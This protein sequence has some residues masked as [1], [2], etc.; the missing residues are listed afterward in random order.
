MLV[1]A[2]IC[3]ARDNIGMTAEVVSRYDN[4]PRQPRGGAEVSA[5][6]VKDYLK[7]VYQ[8]TPLLNA[9]QEVELSK[10]IE[11]GLMAEHV[12]GGA[13]LHGYRPE[14]TVEELEWLMDDG[15]QAKNHML[16][17]NLRLVVSLAKRYNG[18]GLDF[19]DL[20]Q[21][22]NG[23]LIRAVEKFDYTKGYKFSTY[24]T[25][26]VKQSITRAL[27]DQGKTIR[28]PVHVVELMNRIERI[29]RTMTVD[30]GREP[31]DAEL[32]KEADVKE[33]QLAEINEIKKREPISLNQPLDDEGST[34]LGDLLVDDL[35]IDPDETIDHH[36]LGD[37]LEE[38]LSRLNAREADIVRRR[39]G[40]FDG[41][42]WTLK[43]I[44]VIHGV[45]QERI[46]QIEGEAMRKLRKPD[47][48]QH[49]KVFIEE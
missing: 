42:E 31:T 34:E 47:N 43:E 14:P 22:G 28:I 18:R 36:L 33:E 27:A 41:R 44:S 40:L 32:A 6:P 49:L 23:G 29:K 38:S 11:A 20:I 19:M 21:E 16:E 4:M 17:A 45:V 10:R 9:E 37:A 5:D 7:K 15:K 46:R 35:V 39:Y 1:L 13:A 8:G 26:W 12:L 30:L 24:A 25:W 3:C 48:S 2:V